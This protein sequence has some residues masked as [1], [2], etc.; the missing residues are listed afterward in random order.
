M[1]ATDVHSHAK[2]NQFWN[3]VNLIGCELYKLFKLIWFHSHLST[4]TLNCLRTRAKGLWSVRW[5]GYC[6]NFHAIRGCCWWYLLLE[7]I[8]TSNYDMNALVWK[9]HCRHS[10]SWSDDKWLCCFFPLC[11]QFSDVIPSSLLYH[12]DHSIPDWSPWHLTSSALRH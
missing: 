6:W 8:W 1:K 10:S 2:W 5:G 11:A 7:G 3:W 12:K 9:R 4:S